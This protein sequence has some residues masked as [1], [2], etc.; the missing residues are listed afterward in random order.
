VFRFLGFMLFWRF[1]TGRT[2]RTK[3]LR[4]EASR[5]RASEVALSRAD[6]NLQSSLDDVEVLDLKAVHLAVA[7]IAVFAVVVGFHNGWL[8]LIPAGPLAV[9]AVFLLLAFRPRSW[10]IGPDPEEFFREERKKSPSRIN[11]SMV[12]QIM[13][14]A[15]ANLAALRRKSTY[16]TVGYIS[17]GVG[18]ASTFVVAV[19]DRLKD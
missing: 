1:F 11:M 5:L 7:D 12:G 6:A 16:L 8:W 14:A 15:D 17:L 19:L 2:S 9:A 3:R 4:R 13:W 10:D 18:L